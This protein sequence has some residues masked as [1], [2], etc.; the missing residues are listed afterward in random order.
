MEHITV[1]KLEYCFDNGYPLT[2]VFSKDQ[3]QAITTS[4]SDELRIWAAKALVYENDTDLALSM[5]SALAIDPDELVRTEAVDSL[6]AFSSEKS[7]CAVQA[8]LS[9][10]SALVRA[11]AAFGTAIIGKTV[12]PAN[13]LESLIDRKAKETSVYVLVSIYEGM[14]ILGE[15]SC[16]AQ[17]LELFQEN[18]P[19]TQRAVLVALG[20]ILD[21]FNRKTIQAFISSINIKEYPVLVAEEYQKLQDRD[22]SP[23]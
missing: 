1:E 17:L 10:S 9:D 19:Y 22:G 18:D 7:Y 5:L 4:E 13:A 11:Y 21:S 16:L 12:S 2:T 6:S 14:Y 3:L 23:S 20:D 15:K 8:A